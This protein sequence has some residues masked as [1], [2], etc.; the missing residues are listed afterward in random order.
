MIDDDLLAW[1]ERLCDRRMSALLRAIRAMIAASEACHGDQ[2]D[3]VAIDEIIYRLRS[4][5]SAEARH[6]EML[7]AELAW[8][9]YSAGGRR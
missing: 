6:Y 7:Q 2:G 1:H 5:A 3:T 9:G 4:I 8:R